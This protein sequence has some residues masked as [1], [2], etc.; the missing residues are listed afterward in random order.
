MRNWRGTFFALLVLVIDNI[1]NNFVPLFW[2]EITEDNYYAVLIFYAEG[3]FVFGG[4]NFALLLF[5]DSLPYFDGFDKSL[6]I[7]GWL[8]W[9]VTLLDFHFNLN[10]RETGVDWIV[11]ISAVCLVLV[12]KF[13][14]ERVFYSLFSRLKNLTH[15]LT[16]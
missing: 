16:R 10:W 12:A 3:F 5:K 14:K 4:L 9:G 13:Y 11:F 6:L 2:G 15:R 8:T 1:C 7:L